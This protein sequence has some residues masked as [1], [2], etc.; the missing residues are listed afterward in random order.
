MKNDPY[1]DIEL[2]D[3]FCRRQCGADNEPIASK[4][5]SQKKAAAVQQLMCSQIHKIVG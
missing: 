5:L 3:R 1:G 4:W 2:Y